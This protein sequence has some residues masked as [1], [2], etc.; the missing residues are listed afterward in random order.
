MPPVA[1]ASANPLAL[2]AK[3]AAAIARTPAAAQPPSILGRLFAAAAPQAAPAIQTRAGDA[4]P[5]ELNSVF[6]RLRGAPRNPAAP[7]P[8]P[9]SWLN[10]GPRRS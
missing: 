7:V 5:A 10:N 9:H 1:R 2:N 4:R 3:P 8:A 6:D